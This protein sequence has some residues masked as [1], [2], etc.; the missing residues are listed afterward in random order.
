MSDI[1]SEFQ[2]RES[3]VEYRYL[4]LQ[5]RLREVINNRGKMRH[6]AAFGQKVCPDN[7]DFAVDVYLGA[8]MALCDFPKVEESHMHS[9]RLYVKNTILKDLTFPVLKCRR[10]NKQHSN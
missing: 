2:E 8:I 7:K 9:L 1:E 5:D 4:D 3:G 10:C 6:I